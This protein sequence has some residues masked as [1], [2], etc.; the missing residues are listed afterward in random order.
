MAQRAIKASTRNTY[1]EN[2]VEDG[3]M[4]LVVV[5][6][7]NANAP[8]RPGALHNPALFSPHGTY[9]AVVLGFPGLNLCPSI[10]SVFEF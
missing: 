6:W 5:Q 2:H 9:V 8:L 3:K 7:W 10:Y 1:H 4:M